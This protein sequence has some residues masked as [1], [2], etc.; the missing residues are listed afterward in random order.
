M[1]TKQRVR[2][3]LKRRGLLQHIDGI[4]CAGGEVVVWV[5]GMGHPVNSVARAVELAKQARASD[6]A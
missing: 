1:T 6:E 3:G 5:C 2:A 4:E